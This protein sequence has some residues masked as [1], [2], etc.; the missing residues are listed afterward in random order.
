MQDRYA[1]D[2]GDFGKFH[3][4]RDLFYKRNETLY[5]I[6]YKYPNENHNNDGI[7]INYFDKVKG[8]DL[9]LEEK[10]LNITKNSRSIKALEE[11][12]LLKSV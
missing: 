11:A 2:I 5:Q 12:K 3:L 7:H 6:W 4:L 1:G 10:L 9:Y 8:N